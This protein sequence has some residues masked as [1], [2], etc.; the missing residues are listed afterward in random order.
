MF[1]NPV[2]RAY[3]QQ[4]GR[5]LEVSREH[6]R[7]LLDGL[8]RELEERFASETKLTLEMLNM[9]AGP[10]E[11]VAAVLM[12]CI[13]DK[14]RMHYQSRRRLYHK[15]VIIGLIVLVAAI[16]VYFVYVAQ[17]SVDHTDVRIIQSD[18]E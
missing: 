3:C 18:P 6:K 14:E 4:V 15:I 9:S 8:E 13:D 7:C 5:I 10:P 11:K 17:Y 2:I 12:E 1:R 16:T